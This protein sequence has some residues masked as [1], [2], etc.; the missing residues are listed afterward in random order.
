MDEIGKRPLQNDRGCVRTRLETFACSPKP[1]RPL[2]RMRTDELLPPPCKLAN[3]TN[4]AT[5]AVQAGSSSDAMR[6]A[7]FVHTVATTKL[8]MRAASVLQP[9]VRHY[10][11]NGPLYRRAGWLKATAVAGPSIGKPLPLVLRG[12][13]ETCHYSASRFASPVACPIQRSPV[14]AELT[15]RVPLGSLSAS[16]IRRPSSFDL[17]GTTIE[18]SLALQCQWRSRHA[19][20]LLR[21]TERLFASCSGKQ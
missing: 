12:G 2:R 5:N 13:L 11:I 6:C 10:T 9:M 4:S 19:P 8:Y 20:I 7:G 16:S 15:Q 17:P 1:D 21:T 3:C 18:S 14:R